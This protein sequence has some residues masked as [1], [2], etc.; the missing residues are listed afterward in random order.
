MIIHYAHCPLVILLLDPL[1][2]L[3]E[4]IERNVVETRAVVIPESEDSLTDDTIRTLSVD[5]EAAERELPIKERHLNQPQLTRLQRIVQAITRT[6]K[7]K[8]QAKPPGQAI[9][10]VQ[11]TDFEKLRSIPIIEQTAPRAQI[12]I[13]FE[14]ALQHEDLMEMLKTQLYDTKSAKAEFCDRLFTVRDL[15]GFVLLQPL[16]EIIRRDVINML[17]LLQNSL[18][19]IN[20]D[21]LDDVKMEESLS[22]WRGL[23]TRAQFELPDLQRSLTSFINFMPNIRVTTKTS[24][25]SIPAPGLIEEHSNDEMVTESKVLMDQIDKMLRR[26]DTA[27]S[28][29]TQNM[30]LLDSRRSIAEAEGIAKI[31]E[32]AFFFI[33][34]TF[35]AT[36]F[37]MEIE[38]LQTPAPLSLFITIGIAFVSASYIIRLMI[39][40]LWIRNLKQACTESIKIYADRHHTTIQ[41]G[42]IS[43]T[44]FLG[45]VLYEMRAAIISSWHWIRIGLLRLIHT[46]FQLTGFA[47]HCVLF[48]GVIVTGPIAVLWTRPISRGTQTL[49]TILIILIVL[50]TVLITYWNTASTE[51][52]GN[53]VRSWRKFARGL[54]TGRSRMV[55]SLS[56]LCLLTI[57]VVPLVV[58]WTQPIATGIKVPITITIC[59]V[60]GLV[61]LWFLVNK[62]VYSVVIALKS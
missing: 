9:E 50:P 34:L 52:I 42:N 27:S 29:I 23:I 41:R 62:L 60:G 4:G 35:A 5:I 43:L 10:I 54:R 11:R 22:L 3:I 51:T 44:L 6:Q 57:L 30:A 17:K 47:T 58:I 13:G 19:Q 56:V 59:F 16:F 31:T 20:L 49:V 38:Q 32:L 46:I 18:D 26:L 28:S 21:I 40:S 33:P 15:S 8:V 39:R 53:F 37:G 24:S 55:I 45:W 2:T 36:L 14:E 1:P 12:D 48:T 7:E 25:I 61:V